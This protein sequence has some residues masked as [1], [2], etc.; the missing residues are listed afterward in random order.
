[1]DSFAQLAK[2]FELSRERI[3]AIVELID[4][5]NTIPFIARYRKE[6]TGN[7]DDQV[8]RSLHERLQSL[9]AL[10][11]RREDVRR[12]IGETGQ[13]TADIN[14]QIDRA[15][16]VTELDDIYRPYRPKRRTR[17]TIAQERGLEPLALRLLARQDSEAELRRLADTLIDAEKELPDQE[18]VFAGASDIVAETLSNDA[19]LR[20]RLRQQTWQNAM[21]TTRGKTREPSV[22]EA[23]YDYQEP[24][25]RV[26]GHR[27]LAINRGEREKFLSVNLEIDYEVVEPYFRQQ[28]TPAAE[29]PADRWLLPAVADA[30]KRLILPSLTT[31]IRADLTD[32]A[33]AGALD[34]FRVNLRSVLLQPPLR[35]RVVLGIDPGFRTGCKI[36]VVSAVG[37]VL[38][39]G[40]IYP[41][42]PHERIAEAAAKVEQLI[43]KHTVQLI[44]IG[45]GTASRETERF[46]SA[47]IKERGL[48]VKYLLVSE[49][50]AS[51]Y[52]A[53]P[54][55][56]AEFPEYDVSLRSAVSIARRTLDPLAELVKVDP[57]AIG[58]GQ[59]QHDLPEK[60]LDEALTGVVEACVNE[61]GVNL[62]TASARLLSYVAGINETA[63]NSIINWRGQNGRFRKRAELLKVPRIGAR[64]FEQCAGFL[65]IPDSPEYLDTTAVHPE[66]YDAVKRIGRE[67]GAEPSAEL[68]QRMRQ[69]G[70]EKLAEKT[71]LGSLTLA[72]ILAELEKPGRDPREDLPQPTLL[73]DVMEISDLKPGLVL[74][75]VVRNVADFGAFVDIGVHQDGLV[76]ISELSDSFVRH[77]LDVVQPGMAVT[78]R[79]LSVDTARK[80]ISLSMKSE[81][82]QSKPG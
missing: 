48:A 9:R 72:D 6:V 64:T 45:N 7:L 71:G 69:A 25:L 78:V 59:Y 26:P 38:E 4:A 44:A 10:E 15:D 3:A 76:H 37:E 42:P 33:H 77:P 16:T 17:A 43:K 24:V 66:S 50:G 35:G 2:D 63:A 34:V 20:R 46:V 23:F 1:M 82:R 32:S 80:R 79:V 12:L 49:A 21:L 47:L 14:K 41:T 60:K 75:G 62:N 36:C 65:R 68:A 57:K 51:V 19:V 61:V 52:S 22:Y 56:A 58:V 74:T 27:I 73:A 28:L 30:W 39:T 31:E 8:L 13:L 5:G 81:N 29:K 67:L 18:T 11:A 55:A 70:L 54:L 53:S 40:V